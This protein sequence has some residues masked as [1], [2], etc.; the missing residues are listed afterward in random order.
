MTMQG[1]YNAK[2]FVNDYL[3][4]DLPSRLRTYRNEW[5]LDDENLPDPLEYFVH[6]PFAIDTWPTLITMVISMNGLERQDYSSSFDPKYLVDYTMRTYIWVK[7]D[8]PE[9][10]TA[11][12]DRLVTVIRSALLDSPC[13][14]KLTGSNSLHVLIDEASVRE[15]YSDLTLLKGERVMGGAYISYT[16]QMVEMITVE[17]IADSLDEIQTTVNPLTPLLKDL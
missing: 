12:R 2:V 17:N 1:A 9:Q 3:K 6:E 8:D 11:K 15:E 7:D 13:L 10:C 5:N 4:V 14:N 16:L